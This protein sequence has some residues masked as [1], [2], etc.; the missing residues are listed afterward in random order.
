MTVIF[1]TEFNTRCCG[2]T[3]QNDG[4]IKLQK[5]E[6]ISDPECNIF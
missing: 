1:V 4:C 3:F 5:F 2:V 6:D